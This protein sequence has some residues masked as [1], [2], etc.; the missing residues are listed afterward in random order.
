MSSDSL[1]LGHL[2]LNEESIE[3]HEVHN[4]NVKKKQWLLQ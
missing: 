2:Y 3:V 1:V 4:Y